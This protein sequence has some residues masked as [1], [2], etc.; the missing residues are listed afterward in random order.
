MEQKK[1]YR[2]T[3]KADR[4]TK[5]TIYAYCIEDQ[6]QGEKERFALLIEEELKRPVHCVEIKEIEDKRG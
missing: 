4:Y 1:R 5:R 6:V 2:M 3:F